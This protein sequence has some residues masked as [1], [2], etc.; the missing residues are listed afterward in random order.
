M[1]EGQIE[2]AAPVL[3]KLLS[4][5][6]DPSL[7]IEIIRA[8]TKLKYTLAGDKIFSLFQIKNN[9]LQ[10]DILKALVALKAHSKI[11]NVITSLNAINRSVVDLQHYAVL[12]LEQSKNDKLASQI[13]RDIMNYNQ[14]RRDI[15][16]ISKNWKSEFVAFEALKFLFDNYYSNEVAEIFQNLSE[17]Q[18]MRVILKALNHKDYSYKN[19]AKKLIGD[20]KD[21]NLRMGLLKYCHDLTHKDAH[22]LESE[23]LDYFIQND[24]YKWLLQKASDREFPQQNQALEFLGVI[25][26]RSAKTSSILSKTLEVLNINSKSS[27][28]EIRAAV[29]RAY[30]LIKDQESFPYLIQ[31]IDDPNEEVMVRS[32]EALAFFPN[33]ET[34]KVLEKTSLHKQD[35]VRSI[36]AWALGLIANPKSLPILLKLIDD[37]NEKVRS[38]AAL[39]LKKFLNSNVSEKLIK[40]SQSDKIPN[41]RRA[42]IKSLA[43]F[44]FPGV[45]EALINSLKDKD[46]HARALAIESLIEHNDKKAIQPILKMVNDSSGDVRYQVVRALGKFKAREALNALKK[47]LKDKDD[48][49]AYVAEQAIAEIGGTD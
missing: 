25:Q 1:G 6:L 33:D 26:F 35:Q 7:Q 31:L 21:E 30:G 22:A 2:S 45:I 16:K 13:I 19:P 38:K 43:H 8:L 49:V 44:K 48:G 17:Q 28:P 10:F 20:I 24:N 34:L 4:K 14:F 37:P 41:V 40:I 23:L 27:K 12:L 11:Q 15:L 46:T 29:V 18:L 3:L 39:A 32:L 5:K 9:Q 47:L 42:A 36:T